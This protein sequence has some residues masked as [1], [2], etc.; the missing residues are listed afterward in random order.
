MSRQDDVGNVS[1][2]VARLVLGLFG[3]HGAAVVTKDRSPL[4]KRACNEQP[5]INR[6]G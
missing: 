3:H 1:P 5:D 4:M 2:P 6:A